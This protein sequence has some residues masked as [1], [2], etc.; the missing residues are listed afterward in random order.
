MLSV[1]LFSLKAIMKIR[2][3]EVQKDGKTLY[4]RSFSMFDEE[5]LTDNPALAKSYGDHDEAELK[6]DL[7]SISAPGDQFFAR[8]GLR[9]DAPPQLVEFE[10]QFAE[11]SRQPARGATLSSP[12]AVAPV[13]PAAPRR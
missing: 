10:V 2:V 1:T 12:P 3:I 8:S 5:P 7:Q 6:S 9:A 4:A 11:L 13:A